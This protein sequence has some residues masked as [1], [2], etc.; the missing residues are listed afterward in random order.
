MCCMLKKSL[1]RCYLKAFCS[2]CIACLL[3]SNIT[4]ER[5]PEDKMR[6]ARFVAAFAAFVFFSWSGGEG[7]L[8]WGANCAMSSLS[9]VGKRCA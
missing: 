4:M 9:A 6:Y 7:G 3:F 2:T 1:K 8:G 5:P